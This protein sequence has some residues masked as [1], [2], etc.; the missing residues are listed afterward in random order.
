VERVTDIP[1]TFRLSE[2]EDFGIDVTDDGAGVTVVVRGELDVLTAPFL[3][4][5]LE[6][7][8]PGA[9]QSLVLDL[10]GVRFL[11]S[12]GLGVIVRAQSRLRQADG[13]LVVRS[14]Q[15]QARKVFELTGLDRTLDVEA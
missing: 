9:G 7:L 2:P 10:G 3:W 4:E 11:D 15:E 8:L 12:M 1:S 13:Q 5:R 6:P 14:L